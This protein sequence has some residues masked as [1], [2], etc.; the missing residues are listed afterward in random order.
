MWLQATSLVSLNPIRRI[1]VRGGARRYSVQREYGVLLVEQDPNV[2]TNGKFIHPLIPR[3][4]TQKQ[5]AVVEQDPKDGK[6]H[7]YTHP[8]RIRVKR[9]STEYQ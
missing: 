4:I 3:E 7:P 1:L 9:T 2:A 5:Y 6:I 8:F